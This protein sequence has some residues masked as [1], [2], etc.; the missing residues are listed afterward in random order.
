MRAAPSQQQQGR[1]SRALVCEESARRR[2]EAPTMRPTTKR[3]MRFRIDAPSRGVVGFNYGE[4][5]QAHLCR[6]IPFPTKMHARFTPFG[7]DSESSGLGGR[8]GEHT[9]KLYRYWIAGFRREPVLA[10]RD[11]WLARDI[12]EP[13]EQANGQTD[14][15]SKTAQ[16]SHR[17]IYR[18]GDTAR[19]LSN[20]RPEL[21]GPTAFGN[22]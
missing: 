12:E 15:R 6:R 7:V 2:I 5:A 16:H 14:P 21:Q 8:P 22:R 20:R 11:T 4:G 1:E 3:E 19:A 13:K 18:S 9:E 17:P 10:T